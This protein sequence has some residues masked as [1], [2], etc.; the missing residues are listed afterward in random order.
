VLSVLA[1][2]SVFRVLDPAYVER[3]GLPLAGAIEVLPGLHIEAFAV[4]GKTALYL[5]EDE[6]HATVES[7]DTLGITVRETATGALF[8]YVPGCAHVDAALAARLRGAPLVLFDGT[9]YTDH[10]M[11]EQGLSHKSGRRMGHLGISG[12]QGSMTAL[13]QLGI[14]R[15][16][17]I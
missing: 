5:E 14:G 6:G 11:I 3:T 2:N 15:R 17:F 8:S 1:A 7:G 13:A 9:F 4:P 12:P 16:V 10:E